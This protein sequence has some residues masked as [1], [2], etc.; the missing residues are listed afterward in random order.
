MSASDVQ[1]P[2]GKTGDSLYLWAQSLVNSLRRRDVRLE[3]VETVT[4]EVETDN[5][6]TLAAMVTYAG[7][8]QD[9]ITD[10]GGVAQSVYD[11]YAAAAAAGHAKLADHYLTQAANKV[12][13]SVRIA[14]DEV[15]AER[16][17]TLAAYLAGTGATIETI[18]T[19]VANGDTAIATRIDTVETQAGGNS[20]AIQTITSSAG[21]T[22]ANFA[23]IATSNGQIKAGFNMSTGTQESNI[24]FI[25]DKFIIAQV[26]A[27]GTLIT[28]FVVGMVNGVSTVGISG[29][30]VVDGSILA[31]HIAVASLSAISGDIGTVYT[32]LIQDDPVTPEYQ[33]DLE[34]GVIGR[35]DGEMV[36]D[37]K[38][39]FFTITT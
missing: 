1:L 16:T 13:Q 3:T 25:S 36:M 19:A 17:D 15:A 39:K 8:V 23:L 38:N 24:T 10:A 27:P 35:V 9:L 30:L 20:A 37:F 28:P 7:E 5:E 18:E 22:D 34:N 26:G 21:G 32:G 33:F 11:Q 4:T 6:D 14:D 29:N 31:R 12:E 2:R